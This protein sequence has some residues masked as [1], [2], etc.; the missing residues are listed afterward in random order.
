MVE[1]NH[2]SWGVTIIHKLGPFHCLNWKS[3]VFSECFHH[4]GVG[5]PFSLQ[6]HTAAEIFSQ[7]FSFSMTV[8]CLVSW[9]T[10][11]V[12]ALTIPSFWTFAHHVLASWAALSILC[13]VLF[14][15]ALFRLNTIS[16]NYN[17]DNAFQE[18]SKFGLILW[19]SIVSGI[20]VTQDLPVWVTVLRPYKTCFMYFPNIFFFQQEFRF[21]THY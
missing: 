4:D 17:F 5:N 8:S 7:L 21:S 10:C 6:D 11:P 15:T 14:D 1:H 16:L 2:C 9:N 18:K 19:A 12:P 13:C 20:M 3:E